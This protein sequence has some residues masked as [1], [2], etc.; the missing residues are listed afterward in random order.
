[1]TPSNKSD[2]RTT[3]KVGAARFVSR[4]NADKAAATKA[5]F[6]VAVNREG[7]S[8]AEKAEALASFFAKR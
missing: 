8:E 3:Y 5:A 2:T 4:D 6:A 1:M 7:M